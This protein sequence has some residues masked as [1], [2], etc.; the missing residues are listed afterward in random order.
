VIDV[1]RRYRVVRQTVHAWLRCYGDA[2]LADR[3]SRPSRC[4]YHMAPEAGTYPV[5]RRTSI[6][7]ALCAMAS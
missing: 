4:P 7:R 6:Y 1:T 2:G 3:S 5:L